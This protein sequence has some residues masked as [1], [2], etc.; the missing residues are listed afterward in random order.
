MGFWRGLGCVLGYLQSGAKLR[1]TRRFVE[2]RDA[3]HFDPAPANRPPPEDQF[4]R[5]AQLTRSEAACNVVRAGLGKVVLA[6]NLLCRGRPS[7]QGLHSR[8]T[9][10]AGGKLPLDLYC[11]LQS[12][13][14]LGVSVARRHLMGELEPCHDLGALPQTAAGAVEK[15]C[16]KV[17]SPVPRD[18]ATV[19][20]VGHK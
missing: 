10:L 15:P 17:L 13:D 12:N 19:R 2:S 4:E 18:R 1:N 5:F 3:V 14:V 16:E 11:L 8:A 9:H 7:D 6:L 20:T